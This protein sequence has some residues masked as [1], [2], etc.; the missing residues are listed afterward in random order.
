MKVSSEIPGVAPRPFQAI[1]VGEALQEGYRLCFQPEKPQGFQYPRD[2]QVRIERGAD[3][4]P[5]RS[6]MG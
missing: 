6:W 5:R 3:I 1:D 4:G 2:P